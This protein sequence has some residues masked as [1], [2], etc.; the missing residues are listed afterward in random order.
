MLKETAFA[1]ATYIALYAFWHLVHGS[2]SIDELRTGAGAF[3]CPFL[4]HGV[5][6][7]SAWLLRWRSIPALLPAALLHAGYLQLHFGLTLGQT[8]AFATVSATTAYLAFETFRATRLD[9]YA[10]SDMTIHWRRLMLVGGL[11]S[12]YNSFGIVVIG[13]FAFDLPNETGLLL[14]LVLADLIGLMVV[15]LGVW[16]VLKRI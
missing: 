8:L 15:L 12:V 7:I 2:P 13:D 9:L 6:L 4:P 11:A 1:S 14:N 3:L 10:G 5:K 16:A